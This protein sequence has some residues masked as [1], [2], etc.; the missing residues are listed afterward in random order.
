MARM[1]SPVRIDPV[2]LCGL[3]ITII[4]VRGVTR[5]ATSSVSIRKSRSA[6]NGAATATP[7][8]YSVIDS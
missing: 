7:P 3:L 1:S 6:R 5:L 4:R 2:G 8:T